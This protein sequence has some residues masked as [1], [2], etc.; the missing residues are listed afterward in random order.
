VNPEKKGGRHPRGARVLVL[1]VAL[2]A[3]ADFLYRV[4]RPSD[5]WPEETFWPR[6]G[7]AGNTGLFLPWVLGYALRPGSSGA[8]Q[9][10]PED[11]PPKTS[12][13]EDR[14]ERPK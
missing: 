6:I 8:L 1:L 13:G 2:A 5:L 14:T 12:G 4:F 9:Q 10:H 11:D 7:E 3:L